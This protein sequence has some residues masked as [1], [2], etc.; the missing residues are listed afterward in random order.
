MEEKI[1]ERRWLVASG[2]WLVKSKEARFF[3]VVAQFGPNLAKI[4]RK[5]PGCEDA[6]V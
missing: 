5:C 1:P 6:N 3:P 4:L 2:E